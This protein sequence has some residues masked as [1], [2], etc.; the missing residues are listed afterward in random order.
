[1]L[2]RTTLL[3]MSSWLMAV[4]SDA[5]SPVRERSLLSE[6]TEEVERSIKAL[7]SRA[8]RRIASQWSLEKKLAEFVCLPAARDVLAQRRR[9]ERVFLGNAEGTDLKLSSEGRL[10]GLGSYRQASTWYAFR[11]TCLLHQEPGGAPMFLFAEEAND[12][13]AP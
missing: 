11:F 1:M 12:A 5:K 10:S 8:E 6:Y 9:A 3:F 7:P 2:V 4:P 13:N